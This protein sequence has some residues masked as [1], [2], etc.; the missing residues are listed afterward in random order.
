MRLQDR[1]GEMGR[2]RTSDAPLGLRR[3]REMGWRGGMGKGEA[4]LQ[5]EEGVETGQGGHQDV[6]RG[7]VWGTGRGWELKGRARCRK[8]RQARTGWGKGDDGE[9]R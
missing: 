9:G 2:T 8:G 7:E 4:R 1:K 3:G 5:A 6:G